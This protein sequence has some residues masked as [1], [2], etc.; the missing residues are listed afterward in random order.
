MSLGASGAI[1]KALVFFPWKGLDCVRE[2]VV[3]TNPDTTAQ[4]LWRAKLTA[5][6][7]KIHAAQI[8]AKPLVSEDQVSYSTLGS[9]RKTPRTWFNEIVKVWLDVEDEGDV[10]V[11][12]HGVAWTDLTVATFNM[13][14]WFS[15]RLADQ[16]DEGK[17]YFGTT[18]TNMI[19]SCA[20][21]IATGDKVSVANLDLSA[22]LT[23]GKK[24]FVQ[25]KPASTDPCA[26]AVSG[27]YSFVAV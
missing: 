20:G 3:P 26:G 25:F 15:E 12:Y 10:P 13:S 14:L 6:V 21:D 24:Y 2:Y 9:T 19:N 11:I 5:C 1:G 16:L 18:K 4:S 27:I 23:A 22:F 7:A 8:D 17:F